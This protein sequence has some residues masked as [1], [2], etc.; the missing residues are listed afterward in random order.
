MVSAPAGTHPTG[1]GPSAQRRCAAQVEIGEPSGV[2]ETEVY[3]ARLGNRPD[4]V[5]ATLAAFGC[6]LRMRRA[7][8]AAVPPAHG[9][10]GVARPLMQGVGWVLLPSFGM[11][12]A[13]SLVWPGPLA[14]RGARVTRGQSHGRRHRWQRPR[15]ARAPRLGAG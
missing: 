10:E 11:V 1:L 4:M 2:G 12:A 14:G 3:V 15:P 5:H 9:A 7:E 8:R 6:R 13:R